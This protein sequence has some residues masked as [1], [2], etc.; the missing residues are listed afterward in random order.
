[1]PRR[2]LA[3]SAEERSFGLLHWLG[4]PAV[5]ALVFAIVLDATALCNH[6]KLR[7]PERVDPVLRWL[8]VTADMHPVHHAAVRKENDC[9][10]GF[11]LPR[12]GHL[13]E[14][15]RAQREAGH[16]GMT[17]GLEW[18]R[19]RHRSGRRSSEAQLAMLPWLNSRSSA[20]SP[21]SRRIHGS[22]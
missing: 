12:W 13:F 16:R 7:L 14:T 8:V 5:A 22:R 2:R 3:S 9:N 17:I 20:R 11:K 4:A 15:Y 19:R 18:L 21:P 1:M 6:G 10:S